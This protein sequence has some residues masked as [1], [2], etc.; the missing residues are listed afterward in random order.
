MHVPSKK[1]RLQRYSTYHLKAH[2]VSNSMVLECT[3]V[4]EEMVMVIRNV[5]T[6][7]LW[8]WPLTPLTC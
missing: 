3:E 6:T 4:R 7:L 2:R 1:M 8:V 5:N